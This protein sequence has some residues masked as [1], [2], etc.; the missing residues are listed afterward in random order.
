MYH[1]ANTCAVEI[2]RGPRRM[3]STYSAYP[4]DKV[5][6]WIGTAPPATS[7]NTVRTIRR[8]SVGAANIGTSLLPNGVDDVLQGA[9]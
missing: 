8:L 5:T 9:A 6:S 2:T 3:P 1:C 7:A 4:K